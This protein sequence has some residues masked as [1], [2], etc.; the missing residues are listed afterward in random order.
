MDPLP[1]IRHTRTSGKVMQTPFWS[2]WCRLEPLR[3]LKIKNKMP[4][5]VNKK[6]WVT[7]C[8]HIC[9]NFE[10]EDC[11]KHTYSSLPICSIPPKEIFQQNVAK[12]IFSRAIFYHDRLVFWCQ[13]IIFAVRISLTLI[14]KK[15]FPY[16][17][18]SFCVS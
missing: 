8:Q 1:K 9:T 6:Y 18:A 11:L 17:D 16:L 14:S 5:C 3:W 4:W 12:I 7:L 10:L 2:N 15:Y 13:V